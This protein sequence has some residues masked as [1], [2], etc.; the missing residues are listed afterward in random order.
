MN[1]EITVY[2]K[3]GCGGCIFTKK[4]LADKG[5]NFK[6]VDVSKDNEGLARVKSLGYSGLPVVEYEDIHFNGYQPNELDKVINLA[7]KEG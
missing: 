3:P 4:H 7:K 1:K 5:V 2:S 6:E